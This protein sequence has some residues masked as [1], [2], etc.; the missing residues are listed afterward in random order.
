MTRFAGVFTPIVTPFTATDTLDEPALRR[1][2]AHWM[3][4][5]L[6]GLVVLGSN[7]EA[8]QLDDAEADRVIA[9]A[10]DE[11]P[12]ER[13][14]IVGTGRES[15]RAT[16]AAT[17]RAASLGADAVLVRTPSFFKPQ[18]TT[19]IFVRHYREV[20]DAARVPVLLY[21]VSMFTGV[22]LQPEAVE[23]LAS[24][25]NI[26][27]MK[28]SGSDIG[29]IAE[30]VSRTP[31]GFTVLGGSAT[32]LLYSLTAG[33]TGA[34]VALAALVPDACVA[35]WEHV[36]AGR[37]QDA[38]ALQRKLTPL[39]R[40][41]GGG[42]GVPGLKAAL[43]LMGYQGGYPRPPLRP[44]SERVVETIRGQLD[45]LGVLPARV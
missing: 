28:E 25:P 14:F 17:K 45:A 41:I 4:T 30:F 35:L 2:V 40:S 9:L 26:V 1:N 27:G 8:P 38:H 6:H 21:N 13:T 12:K 23:Q 11:V 7:G 16:I 22:S 18:L 20:A 42:Y 44:V 3:K 43:D 32:M 39:A 10:R 5:P 29:L 24:H 15:T 37:F 31:E 33:A 34:I 19:E 36:R